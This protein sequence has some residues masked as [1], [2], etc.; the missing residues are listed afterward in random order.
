MRLQSVGGSRWPHPSLGVGL[1]GS[2]GL[3]LLLVASRRVVRSWARRHAGTVERIEPA[4]VRRR[5]QRGGV[6]LVDAR[7]PAEYARSPVQAPGAL[8]IEAGQSLPDALT[9][10]VGPDGTVI[11][12]CT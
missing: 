9:L 10:R 4:E 11:V 3:V 5:L 7:N 8:R 6:T 2:L 12:Y 1:I